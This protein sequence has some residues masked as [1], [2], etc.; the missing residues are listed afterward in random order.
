MQQRGTMLAILMLFSLGQ[1]FSLALM[2]L[3]CY[4]IEGSLMSYVARRFPSCSPPNS[5]RLIVNCQNVCSL[6]EDIITIP[7]EVEAL[8]LSGDI[9]VLEAQTFQAFPELHYLRLIIKKDVVIS[10]RAFIDLNKLQ[11][12]F[13]VFQNLQSCSKLINICETFFP[14]PSLQTLVLSDVSPTGGD[15]TLS[16]QLQ[17][18][19]VSRCSLKHVLEL[20]HFFLSLKSSPQ[21]SV[22]Q[23]MPD[24]FSS[25]LSQKQHPSSLAPAVPTSW[26]QKEGKSP[27]GQNRCFLQNLR[28][29]F[30]PLTLGDILILALEIEKLDSL[31]L[32]NTNPRFKSQTFPVCDLASR[33]SLCSLSLSRIFFKTFDAVKYDACR[34][35]EKLALVRNQLEYVDSLLLYKM[36]QLQLLDLSVNNLHWGL[37]PP[38][39]K[40]MNFTSKL[41]TMNFS[42]N[43]VS[44]LQAYA[45][46]CLPYLQELLLY[47]SNIER[48]DSMAFY[49][50][51]QLKVLNLENNYIIHLT[52]HSFSSLSRLAFLNLRHNPIEVLTTYFSQGLNMLRELQFG[53]INY[54]DL[55]VGFSIPGLENL[56]LLSKSR[57]RFRRQSMEMFSTLEK[58]T[59]KCNQLE[60][61]SCKSPS[62]PKVKELYLSG[63]IFSCNTSRPFFHDFPL[64]EK[65][66]HSVIVQGSYRGHFNFSHLS[67]LRVLVVF[68]LADAIKDIPKA[69]AQYLFQNLTHLEVLHLMELG[70]EYVS[71]VLFRDMKSLQ[72]LVLQSELILTLDASFQDQ[73]GQLRYFYLNTGNFGCYCSNAWFV[74]W[75]SGKKDLFVS[76]VHP[77]RCQQLTTALK[78]QKFLQFVEH[79][80]ILKIDFI[81]FMATS[82]LILFLMSFLLIHVTCGSELFFLIYLLR[83]WWHRLCGEIG[84]GKRFEYDAFVSYC[85]QDQNWVL[86]NLVPNLERNGPPFLKLCLHSR[87]FVVGKAI[88]DNIM[89]NLYRSRKAICVISP[90]S[91]CN[92]WC[93]L[94]LSLATYRLLAEPDDTLILVFLERRSRYQLSSYHRLA[95]LVK[96]KTYID[97][98]EKP[99]AQ[100]VFWDRLRKSLKQPCGDEEG[101]I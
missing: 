13:I 89:D 37:C 48:I 43:N 21:G 20:L 92:H 30:S 8:C 67:N 28:W 77:L 63:F 50:L 93:S 57:V 101:A 61:D 22:N 7:K 36:P 52:N 65:L 45:F 49:G 90:H 42:G 78:S 23:R 88:V 2:N 9:K 44:N 10:P 70:L 64:L 17:L 82:S 33:F 18:L 39:Y 29:S 25:S 34:S 19:S 94:E 66:H 16:H 15:I 54:G 53:F 98:P 91:L 74:S 58:L 60:V 69:D 6:P 81:L 59:L 80:C 87:D 38:V 51:H 68:N 24:S 56:E 76:I 99:T 73:M 85:R 79:N 26:S 27:E 32:E 83:G 71:P 75:A 5:T 41:Q 96:K 47:A 84:K 35:L 31:S 97:W 62:F 1:P 3:K 4:T 72:L 86:Q 95:K 40:R 12:L 11:Y 100:L 55:D 46:S 14:M